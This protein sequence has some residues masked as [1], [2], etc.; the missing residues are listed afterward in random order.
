MLMFP[1]GPSSRPTLFT[2]ESNNGVLLKYLYITGTVLF[3]VYGQLII[4][5][6]IS[7]NY[8]QLPHHFGEKLFFLLRLFTDGYILS[9]FVAAFLASVFWMAAMTMTNLSFAYPLITAGLT[10]LTT[11]M[12]VLLLGETLSLQ[13]MLGILI[14]LCGIVVMQYT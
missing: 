9:G 14:I 12:A 7:N 3:T 10:L 4:K 1:T 11:V 5:W 13:K 2:K 8:G 6:R